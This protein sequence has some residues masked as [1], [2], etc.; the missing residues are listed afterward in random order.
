MLQTNRKSGNKIVGITF[1]EFIEQKQLKRKINVLKD[2]FKL[3][4]MQHIKYRKHEREVT[5][6]NIEWKLQ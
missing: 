6:Q 4:T 1:I 5:R 3:P 2:Y